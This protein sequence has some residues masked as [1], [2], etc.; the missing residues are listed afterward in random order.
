MAPYKNLSARQRLGDQ[1][2]QIS[3]LEPPSYLWK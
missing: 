2:P 1:R 3:I